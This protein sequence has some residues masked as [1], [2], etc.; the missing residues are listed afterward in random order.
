MV[1]GYKQKIYRRK[2]W[3]DK[4]MKRFSTLRVIRIL[5]EFDRLREQKLNKNP[6]N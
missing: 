5:S 4:N 3:K 2:I 1:K 6:G